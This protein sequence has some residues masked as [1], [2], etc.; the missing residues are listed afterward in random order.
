MYERPGWD[1][2]YLGIAHAVSARGECVRRRVGAIIVRGQSVL[3]TGYN[4]YPAGKESCLTGSCPR[5]TSGAIAGTG[6]A[7]TG[8]RAIHAEANA[9]IRAGREACIGSTI[10]ITDKPCDMCWPLLQAASIKNAVWG[11]PDDY[12]Q[13]RV[14]W[15]V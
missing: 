4:G 15:Y 7:E 6:Y 8:C 5:A 13:E 14:T 1:A 3:A 2:Y 10:Y 9:I 11:S 12:V